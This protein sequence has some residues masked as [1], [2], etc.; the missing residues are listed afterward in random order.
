LR[1][2]VDRSE[3]VRAV[4]NRYLVRDVE[5]FQIAVRFRRQHALAGDQRIQQ[6]VVREDRRKEL[7]ADVLP[8]QMPRR[9]CWSLFVR[10][11]N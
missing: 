9:L 2:P 10:H 6:L 4:A 8:V 1:W 7:A 3:V 11:P 5:A